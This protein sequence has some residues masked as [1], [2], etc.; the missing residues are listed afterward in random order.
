MS[1][2]ESS[3]Q[4][5]VL[6]NVSSN[7]HNGSNYSPKSNSKSTFHV[8]TK[9]IVCYFSLVSKLISILQERLVYFY[10]NLEIAPTIDM[11]KEV[12]F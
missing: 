3:F 8:R 7:E 4:N 10:E 1:Y 11:D 2:M 6:K 12:K 9:N 5:S